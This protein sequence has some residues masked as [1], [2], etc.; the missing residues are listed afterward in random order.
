[1]A[2]HGYR[3]G[4]GAPMEDVGAA[5]D[6]SPESR[7]AL[8]AA[9]GAATAF[10]AHLEII[11][12]VTTELYGAPALVTGPGW[13][14]VRD[15]VE[16]EIRR[17][18]DEIVAATAELVATEGVLLHGR[19]WTELASRSEEL[20]LLFIGSR[21]YG[22]AHSVLAGGTSGALMQH[23]HCPVIVLPRDVDTPVVDIFE[24]TAT[25]A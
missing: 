23:A 5:W 25:P 19:P 4:A 24:A 15:D 16:R 10:D 22:P 6:S 3:I 12:V 13:V 11:T 21:G 18:L 14:T 20:D 9:I 1:V 2:P 7:A 17:D 8:A